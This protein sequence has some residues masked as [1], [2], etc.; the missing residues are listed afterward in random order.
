MLSRAT[1]SLALVILL[2]CGDSSTDPT[3]DPTTS[4]TA[5]LTDSGGTDTTGPDTTGTTTPNPTTTTA[6]PTHHRPHHHRTTEPTTAPTTDAT[7]GTVTADCGFDPGLPF[8]RQGP[9]WQLVSDDGETCVLLERR[10]DSEPDVIYKAVPYTLLSFKIG[11]AGVVSEYTDL[12]QLS[13]EST[14]HNWLDVAEAWDSEVRYRLADR[15]GQD[16]L[17][18]FDLGAIDEQSKAPLWGPISVHPY[19]P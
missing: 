9:I 12:A 1:P 10:D 3:G 18:E 7:T 16:F 15:Y 5:D 11:H 8:D 4:A 2:G 13:W 6:P 14:H 19:V 17:D